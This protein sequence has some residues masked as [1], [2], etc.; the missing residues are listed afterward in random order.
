MFLIFRALVIAFRSLSFSWL[1][2]SLSI[3]A[4]AG[5]VATIIVMSA[6]GRGSQEAIHEAIAKMGTNLIM[7]SAGRAA[8]VGDRKRQEKNLTTLRPRD[9]KVLLEEIP[10]IRRLAP[11]FSKKSSVRY[12]STAASTLVLGTTP[13]YLKIRNQRVAQGRFFEQDEERGALRVAIIGVKVR[14][15][16][17]GKD[18]DPIGETIRVNRVLFRVIGVLEEQGASTSGHDEDNVVLIPLR[19]ALRRV[20]NVVHL[21]KILV[22]AE[23]EDDIELIVEKADSILRRLHHIHEGES[24]DV[25]ISSQA[26]ILATSR[27]ASRRLQWM[28]NIASFLTL[29][30]GGLGIFA[31][32]TIGLQHRKNEIGLRRAIGATHR[33]ILYQFIFEAFLLALIGGV[34]GFILSLMV[35]F[36]LQNLFQ[37][38]L[39]F[40]LPHILLAE[41][42]TF[43]VGLIA[44]SIPAWKASQIPPVEALRSS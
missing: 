15:N 10:E 39:S 23:R 19:T 22:E 14:D 17:F 36:L 12:L 20:F 2:T 37:M 42:L 35:G 8:V 18:I 13:V 33:D 31:V 6:V 27:D 44:G 28:I 21:T 26:E 38:S 9:L 16:L 3:A 30:I 32:M 5:G 43:I 40:S 4:M 24:S 34:L 29:L 25:V 41:S 7:I 11:I 1:R